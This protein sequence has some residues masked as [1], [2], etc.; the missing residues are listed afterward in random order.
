MKARTVTANQ[1]AMLR[2]LGQG[3]ER[4]PDHGHRNAGTVASGWYR[5]AFSLE[6]LGLVETERSGDAW[7]AKLTPAGA[8][9]L[10]GGTT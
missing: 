5:T 10:S 1:M 7:L 4:T 8:T 3:A 9:F 2:R 6:R